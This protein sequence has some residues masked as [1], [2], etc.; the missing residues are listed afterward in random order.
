VK[1]GA[2]DFVFLDECD[3]HAELSCADGGRVATTSAAQH[4]EVKVEFSH[5]ILLL[6]GV[7]SRRVDVKILRYFR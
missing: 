5:V 3:V 1:A 7:R 6:R 4:D 2:T